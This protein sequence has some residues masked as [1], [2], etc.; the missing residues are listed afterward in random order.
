MVSTDLMGLAA[1]KDGV[2]VCWEADAPASFTHRGLLLAAMEV[3]SSRS[4]GNTKNK[5]CL[6]L[7]HHIFCPAQN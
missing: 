6:A 3:L 5:T 1:P 2:C 7:Y 4:D